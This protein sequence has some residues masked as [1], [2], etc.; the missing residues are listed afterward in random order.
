LPSLTWA[1]ARALG[2][3]ALYRRV[4]L[5]GEFAT[6]YQI[7]LDNRVYQGLAG[8]HVVVPLRLKQGGAI[9]VN[10]GWR[11]AGIRDRLPVIDDPTGRQT[12][13]GIL[14]PARARYLELAFG[15]DAGHLW[16]NLDLDRYRAWFGGNLSDW[17][18]LRTDPVQDRLV[19]QWPA[20]DVGVER[21]RS[22]ALQWFALA[23]LT[24]WL[25]FYYVVLKRVHG[26]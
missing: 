13:E 17:L 12:V 5:T 1:E 4:R 2:A 25:W 3:S 26:K 19:R 22:Y 21:H 8:Y 23:A 14:V 10:R 24:A 9:L 7:L 11:E 18:L 6:D 16:Q 20:P 15:S